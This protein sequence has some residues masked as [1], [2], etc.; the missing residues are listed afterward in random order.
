MGHNRTHVRSRIACPYAS[1]GQPRQIGIQT[2]TGAA[3]AD[4]N[5]PWRKQAIVEIVDD[6]FLPLAT[7]FGKNSH[8]AAPY[9]CASRQ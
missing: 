5:A 9:G 6:V 2:R 8:R 7:N 4:P 3:L 1:S